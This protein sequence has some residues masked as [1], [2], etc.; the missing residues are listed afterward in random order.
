MKEVIEIYCL[1]ENR[2][3]FSCD[4][5]DCNMKSDCDIYNKS[6]KMKNLRKLKNKDSYTDKKRQ[7]R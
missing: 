5:S 1:K 3:T 7:S 4:I 6:E 2:S